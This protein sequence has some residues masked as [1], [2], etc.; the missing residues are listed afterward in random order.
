MHI[1]YLSTFYPFRGGIAQFNAALYREFEKQHEI[2]A[3]TFKRQYPSMLFPGKTQY[4]TEGDNT[5]KIKSKEWLDSINPFNWIKTASRIKKHK[6]D[7]IIMKYWTSFF[8]P[9][10]GSICKRQKKQSKSIAILDNVIP[11]EKRIIDMPF[12]KYFLKHTDG[13]IVMSE[14]VQK[15]LLK[16]KP[17]AKYRF[18]NHPL[19]NHFGKAVNQLEARK[20]LGLHPE[21]KTLLFFGFI[22]EY[23]GL[24][25]LIDAFGKLNDSYQLIIAGES[26]GSFE[27]YDTQIQENKNTDRIYKYVRYINDNEVPLFFSAADT[28]ILPYKSATQSGITSISFNFELPMIAT[29]VGGLKELIKH[30]KTGEI[31]PLANSNAI[32]AGINNFFAGDKINTY[33][34]NFRKEK[35]KMTWKNLAK[36]ILEL[37]ADL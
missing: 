6:P 24:D 34:K 15:D 3:I 11:H 19:Y 37:Y 25:L 7:L 29:D 28:C 20:K 18:V 33:R 1:S 30:E 9:S 8:G 12:T 10:L 35:S 31:I 16:I 17:D 21:K 13:Y 23:K 5:D 4:V 2:D 14:K 36:E 26:Y 27:K 22:R 32:T